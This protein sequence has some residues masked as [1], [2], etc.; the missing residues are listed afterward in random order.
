MREHEDVAVAA[1]EALRAWR[2][3]KVGALMGAYP[4]PSACLLD[5]VLCVDNEAGAY[6]DE[7]LE[8]E[9]KRAESA[10]RHL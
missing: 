6:N 10:G 1:A 7:L 5:L 2:L 8:R 3:G 4:A 9:R